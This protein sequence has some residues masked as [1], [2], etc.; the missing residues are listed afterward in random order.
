VDSTLAF[1]GIAGFL[2]KFMPLAGL[3]LLRSDMAQLARTPVCSNQ[4][5]SEGTLVVL[6]VGGALR[7]EYTETVDKQLSTGVSRNKGLFQPF[8]S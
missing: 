2:D 6:T 7:P 3:R 5:V 1:H 8:L 4:K